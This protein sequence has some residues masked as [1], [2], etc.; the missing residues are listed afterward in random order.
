MPNTH[1][2][3]IRESLGKIQEQFGL[4]G[5]ELAAMQADK[6]TQTIEVD[7]KSIEWINEYLPPLPECPTRR[8]DSRCRAIGATKVTVV[9][10]IEQIDF[11]SRNVT[12]LEKIL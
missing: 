8:V 7:P 4:I 3:A 1:I 5:G 12:V 9:E 11:L 6:G 10:L 2:E